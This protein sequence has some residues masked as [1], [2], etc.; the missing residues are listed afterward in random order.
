MRVGAELLVPIVGSRGAPNGVAN[1]SEDAVPVDARRGLWIDLRSRDA[2]VSSQSQVARSAVWRSP[3]RRSPGLRACV[4][5]RAHCLAQRGQ[6]RSAVVDSE[7]RHAGRGESTTAAELLNRYRAAWE[8]AESARGCRDAV[9]LTRVPESD[10]R[11]LHRQ[12]AERR[13]EWVR[14]DARYSELRLRATLA[15]RDY[16]RAVLAA[17]DGG[18]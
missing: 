2:L 3:L 1:L 9:A 5:R 6:V 10:A 13:R 18:T 4:R 15:W 16:E 8:T 17:A 11:H 12:T 14:L 7:G